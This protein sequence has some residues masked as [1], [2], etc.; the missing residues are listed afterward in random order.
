[1][2][3]TVLQTR[4]ALPLAAA[5]LAATVLLWTG[6]RFMLA[7]EVQALRE[8]RTEAAG[9]RAAVESLQLESEVIAGFPRHLA[10]MRALAPQFAGGAAQRLA[11]LGALAEAHGLELTSLHPEPARRDGGVV[12]APLRVTVAGGYRQ[13]AAFAAEFATLPGGMALG[14]VEIVRGET[15]ALVMRAEILAARFAPPGD[16]EG[17]G[18]NDG[19]A[20]KTPPAPPP[21]LP[22][23]P[24]FAVQRAAEAKSDPFAPLGSATMPARTVP[25][26]PPSHAPRLLG[27]VRFGKIF[28]AI[29]Q[30]AGGDV[31]VAIGDS[32]GS[33]RVTA[34]DRGSVRLVDSDG[35]ESRVHLQVTGGDHDQ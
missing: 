3:W 28:R 1:M 25:P 17:G 15:A 19:G 29:L 4:P 26:P 22:A 8:A 30:T 33:L 27:V 7:D 24:W 23:A 6:Y 34:I 11:Q 9:L 18:E 12:L 16:G 35:R 14:D 32:A 10:R 2:D 31:S 13:L 5:A 20:A 21:P